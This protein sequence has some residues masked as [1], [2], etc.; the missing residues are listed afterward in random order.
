MDREERIW[1]GVLI[2][3]YGLSALFKAPLKPGAVDA[4]V[5]KNWF[6]WGLDMVADGSVLMYTAGVWYLLIPLL[7]NRKLYGE[8]VG[9]LAPRP[10]FSPDRSGD[11]A[12][13]CHLCFDPHAD[14]T[15]N[16]QPVVG[17]RPLLGLACGLGD[18]GLLDGDGRLTG[19]AP[20]DDL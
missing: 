17:E 7:V 6:W 3:V 11:A 13:R 9:C 1:F 19:H 12:F 20:Q 4:L 2:L 10:H 8:S 14:E 15:G 16:P 18:H 5:Y